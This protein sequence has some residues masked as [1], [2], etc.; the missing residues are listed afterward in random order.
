[1]RRRDFLRNSTLAGAGL[2]LGFRGGI[3]RVLAADA[4]GEAAPWLGDFLRISPTGEVSFLLVKH[5]M[6]QGLATALPQ[7]LCEE[8]GA[9]WSRVRVEFPPAD[10]ARW[11]NDHNGGHGTGGSCSIT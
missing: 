2:L 7:I 1:M 11:E 6:G 9:D 8:L 10:M 4:S 5:E 3:P